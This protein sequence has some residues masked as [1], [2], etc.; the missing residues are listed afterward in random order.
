MGLD[1]RPLAYREV[2]VYPADLGELVEDKLVAGG[3]KENS[4]DA[5]GHV[6][7]LLVRGAAITVAISGTSI[8]RDI[9]VPTDTTVT[10]FG[11][12]DPSVGPQ[13]DVFVVQRPD[14]IYAER[15]SL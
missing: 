3:P 5:N 15:R 12:L 11:L 6:E 14:I 2:S 8:V 9:V 4:T 7:F 10:V 1:G 13:D